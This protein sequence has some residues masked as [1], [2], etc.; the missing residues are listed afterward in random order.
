MGK[1]VSMPRA[2][3]AST[4]RGL[5]LKF[6]TASGSSTS[7]A[8]GTAVASAWAFSSSEKLSEQS[9]LSEVEANRSCRCWKR[10]T[11]D[12]ALGMSARTLA[13]LPLSWRTA[14]RPVLTENLAPRELVE[15][16]DSCIRRMDRAAWRRAARIFS[17]VR[18][19]GVNLSQNH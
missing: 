11:L 14:G 3:R 10:E 4:I 2:V 6:L 15:V 18:R 16:D 8:A 9:E 7:S 17:H 1:R 5:M 12:T 13:T 19:N